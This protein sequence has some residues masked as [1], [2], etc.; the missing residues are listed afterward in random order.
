MKKDFGPQKNLQC[1]V[2]QVWGP[3]Y[4]NQILT[5]DDKVA[6][7]QLL[8]GMWWF[9][10]VGLSLVEILMD[11]I[12]EN[13]NNVREFQ[14]EWSVATLEMLSMWGKIMI[15]MYM[16]WLHSLYG[17]YGPRCPPS[18][19]RPL[20]LITHSLTLRCNVFNCK[21]PTSWKWCGSDEMDSHSAIL[22]RSGF[23]CFHFPTRGIEGNFCVLGW[24]RTDKTLIV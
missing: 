10:S 23:L 2:N 13:C 14:L 1:W 20:D 16:L 15:P 11:Y 18:P 12:R 19:E 9:F 17:Q 8:H 21:I 22:W 3:F 4:N 5:G 24:N 6:V 7:L